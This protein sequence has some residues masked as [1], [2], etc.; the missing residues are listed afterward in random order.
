MKNEK[1]KSNIRIYLEEGLFKKGDYGQLT[2]FYLNNAKRTLSTSDALMQLSD[3]SSLKES[4][5]LLEDFETYMWVITTSY[6][7]MFYALNALFS[8]NGIKIGDRIAH[9][10][11][12][13][14]F[15]HYF[16]MNNKIAK[17]M[18][19]I[20]EEAKDTALDLAAYSEKAEELS[21]NLEFEMAKRHKFQYNM[22][23]TVKRSQAQ[24]SLKRAIE[25]VNEIEV[26]IKK[27]G[28]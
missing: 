11:S 4:F 1:I 24:T 21:Q 8:N 9:K 2:E 12:C 15:Y 13:D 6:Y 28:G 17:E 3:K 25:F 10:V 27:K 20:Y 14:L 18:F 19:E 22:T 23:A 26:L 7:S 5:S 16:V